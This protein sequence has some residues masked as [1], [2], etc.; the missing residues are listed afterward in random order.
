MLLV[1]INLLLTAAMDY[2]G[3]GQTLRSLIE[4]LDFRRGANQMVAIDRFDR[5]LIPDAAGVTFIHCQCGT[6]GGTLIA[7]ISVICDTKT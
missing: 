1:N 3:Y 6:A 4:F 2:H 5:F 7:H